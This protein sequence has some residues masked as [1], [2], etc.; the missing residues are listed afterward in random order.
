[1][2]VVELAP[3]EAL[4]LAAQV[5]VALAGFAG[6]VAAFGRGPIQEWPPAA[7][8]RLKFLLAT[9]LLPLAWSLFGLMLMVSPLPEPAI[10]QY[11]SGI[12]AVTLVLGGIDNSREYIALSRTHLRDDASSHLF[13][14]GA[15]TAGVISIAL[16]FWNIVAV[17]AFWPFFAMI[18]AAMV[19]CMLQFARF[20][21]DRPPVA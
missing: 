21:L 1:M 15:A 20:I 5:A 9:G 11:C 18:V 16:Q 17:K 13:F 19:V 14:A 8:L 10:W 12:S 3:S 2:P 4:G 7:R 6:I